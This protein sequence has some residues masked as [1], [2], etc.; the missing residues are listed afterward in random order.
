MLMPVGTIEC[1]I[2]KCDFFPLG[3]AVPPI[4][5]GFAARRTLRTPQPETCYDRQASGKKALYGW[6]LVK[7]SPGRYRMTA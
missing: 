3:K 5:A 2:H 1:P 6:T 7:D 4:V